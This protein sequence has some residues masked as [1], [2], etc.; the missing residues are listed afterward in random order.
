MLVLEPGRRRL[1]RT[2][3]RSPSRSSKQHQGWQ[4]WAVERR[5]NFL[6]NQNELTKYKF[7]VEDASEQFFNYY[8]GYLGTRTSQ[9]LHPVP[10]QRGVRQ[11]MGHERRGRR[12]E[13]GDRTRQRAWRQGRAGRPL[14]RR[15]GRHRVCDLG[16][17]RQAAGPKA[18]RA[19]STTTAAAA[20]T[21]SP[22]KKPKSLEKA[23]QNERNPL[24]GVRRDLVPRPGAFLGDRRG[25]PGGEPKGPSPLEKFAFLPPDLQVADH[26][27]DQR[28]RASATRSTSEPRR[29]A[30]TRLRYTVASVWKSGRNR[31][32]ARL[33]R[34]RRT[35]A[36][37]PLCRNAVGH[38]ER[39]SANGSEW[40]FPARLT[41]DTGAVG[42]GL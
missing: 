41:L 18:S 33:E 9:A 36:G 8:L 11:G 20:R 42:N 19:S 16:L 28:S 35:N 23:R 37:P 12:P 6:E 22:E 25:A 2:S 17:R 5:E 3:C 39:R 1:P 7:E 26:A 40:Y 21:R 32:P 4:V 15:L 27:G 30:A 13:S 24:A 34:R 29:L 14:A 10:E 31:R 38:R